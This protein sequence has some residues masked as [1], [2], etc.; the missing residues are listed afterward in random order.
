MSS[1]GAY[2]ETTSADWTRTTSYADQTE[3]YTTTLE[4]SFT[5]TLADAGIVLGDK[6]F[7]LSVTATATLS[8]LAL[9]GLAARRRRH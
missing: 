1:V 4:D 5:L 7:S 3:T 8:L 9:A 6:S 2:A